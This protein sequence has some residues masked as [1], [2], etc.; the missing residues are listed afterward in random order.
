MMVL[1]VYVAVRYSRIV[2]YSGIAE[3]QTVNIRSL[4]HCLMSCGY[5]NFPTWKPLQSHYF[6]I[7]RVTALAEVQFAGKFILQFN[8]NAKTCVQALT[9]KFSPSIRED[10]DDTPRKRKGEGRA[11]TNCVKPR[12]PNTLIRP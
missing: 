9:S 12:A 3:Y 2:R 8:K 6:V 4:G 5:F 10:P 1:L 7:R 11:Y